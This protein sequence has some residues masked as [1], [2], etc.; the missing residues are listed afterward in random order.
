MT[1]NIFFTLLNFCIAICSVILFTPAFMSNR[2]IDLEIS[3]KT[4]PLL[5]KAVAL[6]SSRSYPRTCIYFLVSLIAYVYIAFRDD[7]ET[8]LDEALFS[9]YVL[10]LISIARVWKLQQLLGKPVYR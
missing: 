7:M 10:F 9:L 3:L 1:A 8:D 5:A 2:L 4:R 6:P